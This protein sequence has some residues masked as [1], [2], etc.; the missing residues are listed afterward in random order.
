M[1]TY[2][3]ALGLF[4][5]F[6]ACSDNKNPTKSKEDNFESVSHI[7]YTVVELPDSFG[8]PIAI[9]NLSEAYSNIKGIWFGTVTTPWIKPYHVIL[10][11][12][13]NN[14]YKSFNITNNGHPSFYY[15]VDGDTL[16]KEF[17]FKN[18]LSD[19]SIEGN[20]EIVFSANDTRMDQITDLYFYNNYKD[21]KFDFWHGEFGPVSFKLYRLNY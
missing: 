15:G 13:D 3:F 7:D 5:L 12:N 21:V 20:M 2:I 18:I 10:E 11:F 1:K 8:T 19:G 16:N 6:F 17:V 14:L 9:S 4:I